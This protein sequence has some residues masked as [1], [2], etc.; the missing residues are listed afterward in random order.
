MVALLV[1]WPALP[2]VAVAVGL[3]VAGPVEPELPPVVVAV[4]DVVPDVAEPDVV[5][6][7]AAEPVEPDEPD[8]PDMAWSPTVTAPEGPVVPE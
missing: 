6:D 7:D 4:V 5:T 1:A 3:A 8:A 2:L